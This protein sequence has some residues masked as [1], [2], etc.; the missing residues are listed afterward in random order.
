M[1]EI[2]F[3]K[4]KVSPLYSDFVDVRPRR[5]GQ[6]A[7]TTSCRACG[8][9]LDLPQ[10]KLGELLE[11]RIVGAKGQPRQEAARLTLLLDASRASLRKSTY[12]TTLSGREFGPRDEPSSKCVLAGGKR[13]NTE[14]CYRGSMSKADRYNIQRIAFQ[15]CGESAQ[16]SAVRLVHTLTVAMGLTPK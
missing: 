16:S 10:V 14:P 11:T 8:R 12:Q 7:L 2:I 15:R 4:R 1:P 3:D 9:E 5:A 6:R 13:V